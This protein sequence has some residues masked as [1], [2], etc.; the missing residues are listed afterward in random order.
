MYGICA[1]AI[2]VKVCPG[3]TGPMHRLPT[4]SARSELLELRNNKAKLGA[5]AYKFIG[6]NCILVGAMNVISLCGEFHCIYEC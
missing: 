1:H 6:P 2:Q 3:I 4:E 5:D